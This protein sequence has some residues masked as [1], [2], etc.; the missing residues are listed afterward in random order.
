MPYFLKYLKYRMFIVM[1]ISEKVGPWAIAAGVPLS[2]GIRRFEVGRAKFAFLR[3]SIEK[4]GDE[5]SRC[6]TIVFGLC[7]MILQRGK[8]AAHRG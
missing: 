8:R 3:S 4:M 2:L 7:W 6:M 5:Q 1:P